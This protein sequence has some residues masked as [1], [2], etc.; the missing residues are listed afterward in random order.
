MTII[1]GLNK[2]PKKPFFNA[3]YHCD[4]IEI[5]ALSANGDL[6]SRNDIQTRYQT[7]TADEPIDIETN[8]DHSTP[9]QDRLYSKVLEWFQ[10]LQSREERFGDYYPFLI[11][12]DL[13]ITLKADLSNKQ[14]TYIFLLLCSNLGK[15]SKKKSLL[16]TDFEIL[17]AEVMKSYLQPFAVVHQ[18]G[19]SGSDM[20]RYKGHITNKLTMLAHDIN[21]P[22]IFEDHF[23]AENDSGDGG[24]DIVAWVPFNHDDNLQNIQFFV[25]QCATGKNW[26]NKQDEPS[27]I[28]NYISLPSGFT[29]VLF[30]PYDGRN[31]DNKFNEQAKITCEL[32]FDRKRCLSLLS[33]KCNFITGFSSYTDCVLEA[34]AFE[35]DII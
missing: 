8:N 18:L 34:V 27:K 1:Q 30:V 7:D 13:D 35:E 3:H 26:T 32:L 5:I 17:S 15:I 19:K 25:G 6:T 24:M 33:D 23:F 29:I 4:F 2:P 11:S 9:V 10:L 31:M 16:T 20:E 12:D 22:T 14:Y 21:R 28:K